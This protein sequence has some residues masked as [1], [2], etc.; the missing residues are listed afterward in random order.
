MEDQVDS[1]PTPPASAVSDAVVATNGPSHR[2]Y[3]IQPFRVESA[4]AQK[5]ANVPSPN[6]SGPTKKFDLLDIELIQ[7]YCTRTYLTI[8]SRLA[9]HV[10]WRDAVFNEAFRHEWLLNGIMA[11]AALHKASMLQES[12]QDYAKVALAH[13]N[14]ALNG[15]IPEVSRP[16]QDN[17]IAIFSLSLLLTI[18][19]FASKDLPEGLKMVGANSA[20]GDGNLDVR[21]PLTSPTLQ[22]AQIITVLRGIYTIIQETDTWLRGFSIEEM[23]RYPRE[24]DLP[25]HPPDLAQAYDSLA[26]AVGSYQDPDTAEFKDLCLGQV[27]R[28]RSIS[29]C[30]SVVE[31]DGHIFS[32]FIMA[33]VAYING[34]KQ[35]NPMALAVFAYWAACLRCM[36]HHWW[37]NGWP[38]TLVH[39]ISNLLDMRVWGKAMDWPRRQCGLVFQDGVPYEARRGP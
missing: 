21:L 36:D 20:S 34:I 23:L 29:R 25:P 6:I 7:H 32:F 24:D 11:T 13:Q 19:A 15:Y 5:I 17:S 28:L 22:F 1:F 3:N 33:P 9:T 10:I 12:S 8:S 26:E 39:D 27:T 18:W 37:A 16:N 35:G 2:G 4:P 14:A 30:R 38:Q 31:W